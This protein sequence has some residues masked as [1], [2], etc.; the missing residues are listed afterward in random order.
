[1]RIAEHRAICLPGLMLGAL[2][3]AATVGAGCAHRALKVAERPWVEVKTARVRL[4]GDVDP[5]VLVRLGRDLELFHHYLIHAGVARWPER[6]A[7]VTI[8]VVGRNSTYGAFRLAPGIVGWFV[9]TIRASYAVVNLDAGFEA[10]GIDQNVLFHEFAHFLLAYNQSFR[11]P[12]WYEEG[13]AESLS[14][15]RVDEAG[16]VDVGLP[17]E[18][19]IRELAED[20]RPLRELFEER[21]IWYPQAWMTV[22]YLSSTP[23]RY[24]QLM[25]Y[26]ALY[27]AGATSNEA[28]EQAFDLDY[29]KLQ[30]EIRKYYWRGEY[31]YLHFEPGELP[32]ELAQ[33]L[34]HDARHHLGRQ[35]RELH[36][37]VEAVAELGA[38]HVLVLALGVARGAAVAEAH[39]ALLHV[40]RAHV[41]RHEE[42]DVAEVRGFSVVVGE[43]AVVHHLQEDVEHVGV[44]LLDL[45]EQE[46]RVRR[47]GDGVGL[48]LLGRNA[49]GGHRAGVEVE[50]QYHGKGQQKDG[51]DRFGQGA[52]GPGGRCLRTRRQGGKAGRV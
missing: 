31:A 3:V 34:P 42:H 10:D 6:T 17:S 14:T 33:E 13:F 5:A 23:G 15:F 40:A 32:V 21:P 19:R 46:H 45:V 43:L 22:H 50:Y 30:A 26:L 28:F 4:L 12:L 11:Y 8:V 24:D 49:Q 37:R 9:P 18:A 47:L 2:L 36:A 27:D 38:E 44:G 48:K 25:K 51:Q 29:R 7:P 52:P 41:A 39:R 35:R 20:W 16:G 1:M